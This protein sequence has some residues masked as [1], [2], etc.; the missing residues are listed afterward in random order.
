MSTKIKVIAGILM[1]IALLIGGCTFLQNKIT[2][3]SI[4][5]ELAKYAG[6]EKVGFP[7]LEKLDA[8][9]QA[10]EIKHTIDQATWDFYKTKDNAVYTEVMGRAS[11]SLNTAIKDRDAAFGPTGIVWALMGMFGGGSLATMLTAAFKDKTMYSETE[12]ELI[13][14]QAKA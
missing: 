14:A 12:V 7:S 10:A 3:A 9:M 1:A 13:K 11:I 4:S 8:I 5:P 2:P 6:V